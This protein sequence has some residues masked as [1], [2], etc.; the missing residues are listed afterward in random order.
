MLSKV[1]V[2][3]YKRV[4]VTQHVQKQRSCSQFV[5]PWFWCPRSGNWSRFFRQLLAFCRCAVVYSIVKMFTQKVMNHKMPTNA[6][7]PNIRKRGN[8]YKNY[9][10]ISC[11]ETYPRRIVKFVYACCSA[12]MISP[13]PTALGPT[14]TSGMQRSGSETPVLSVALA[15]VH[16]SWVLV[17]ADVINTVLHI[18]R[19][20][21]H[22]K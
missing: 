5:L 1:A 13:L 9:I 2:R 7:S 14:I 15:I 8:P 19:S 12:A 10:T 18:I 22:T 20:H 3:A 11:T 17:G 6:S 4:F 16:Q 21:S